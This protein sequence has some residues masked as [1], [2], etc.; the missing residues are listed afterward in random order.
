[1][2]IKI[3]IEHN[4]KTYAAEVA[5]IKSTSLGENDRGFF[6]AGFELSGDGWGVW[7]GGDY[8][9]DGKPEGSGT[10]RTSTAY[11]MDYVRQLLRVAGVSRWEKLVGQRI[12][13]L[14]E[15]SGGWG[16]QNVG[17]ANIDT[18]K[19]F[20]YQEHADEWKDRLG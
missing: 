10:G 3:S 1:M 11:G 17:L 14:A 15:G 5:T 12:Y 4:G 8:A 16:S 9:L 19:V 7:A 2:T 6:T 20:I 13:A 18:G